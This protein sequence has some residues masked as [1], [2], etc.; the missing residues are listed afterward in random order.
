MCSKKKEYNKKKANLGVNSWF[1]FEYPVQSHKN[2]YKCKQEESEWVEIHKE[3][4]LFICTYIVY[5]IDR[6]P[7]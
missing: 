5:I 4:V 1:A 3:P 2:A 7:S 6:K